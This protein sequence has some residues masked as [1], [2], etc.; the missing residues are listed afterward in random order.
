MPD[1]MRSG[2]LS[3][4]EPSGPVQT[5]NGIAFITSYSDKSLKKL[6]YHRRNMVKT[7]LCLVQQHA[8]NMCRRGG[9]KVQLHSFLTS[10]LAPVDHSPPSSPEVKNEWIYASTP[11]VCHHGVHRNESTNFV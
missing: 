10:L 8:I 6:E 9:G 7:S 3:L 11:S 5:C 2:N 1:V 4:L